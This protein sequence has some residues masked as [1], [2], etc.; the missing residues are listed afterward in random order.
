MSS[1]RL[2]K[3]YVH[4]ILGEGY[5]VGGFAYEKLI[6]SILSNSNLGPEKATAGAG[7]G[8]DA[9][10]YGPDGKEYQLEVK[11]SPN[12][13]AGQKNCSYNGSSLDWSTPDDL[14]EL[15][16][17]IGLK[18]IILGEIKTKLDVTLN[19]LG[20]EKLPASMTNAEYWNKMNKKDISL[21]LGSFLVPPAAIY[22]N[23]VNK[24]VHYIQLG[25]GYGFYYLDADV[26]KL[27]VPQFS[28]ANVSVRVRIK[29]GGSSAG[30]ESRKGGY[31]SE[32][33][34]DP[35]IQQDR[36]GLSLNVGLVF[37]GLTPSS[38]DITKDVSFLKA[39]P[40]AKMKNLGRQ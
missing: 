33:A 14:T 4:V 12:V 36:N 39:K 34:A 1:L 6:Q 32:R 22:Q 17:S 31:N 37:K 25:D 30:I 2:L 24:D 27:G 18:A 26:A 8:A 28:P 11:D 9:V 3:E 35:A 29:W 10:F 23:Y 19:N 20:I 15:Y 40:M 5:A 7:H 16:D 21:E 13:F 38:F